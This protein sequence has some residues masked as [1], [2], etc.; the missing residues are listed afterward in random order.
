MDSAFKW[1][2]LFNVS[3]LFF[4][5]LALL[6]LRFWRSFRNAAPAQPAATGGKLKPAAA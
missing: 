1:L 2:M 3:Q 4:I 5:A 6:P